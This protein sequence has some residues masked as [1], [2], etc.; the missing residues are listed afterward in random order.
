MRISLKQIA[1][2]LGVSAA[3]VSLVLNEKNGNGRISKE[4]SKKVL[5][6]AAELNYTPN[7]FAKGLKTGRSKTL[8]LIL[9]DISNPF[10][11]RL[12]L[13]VQDYAEKEGYTVLVA[14][15]NEKVDKTRKMV[16]LLKARQVDGFI[17]TP[18]AGSE[19][20][21]EE[22]MNERIP[23]V[24]VDR[25]FPLL[26]T[27][28]VLIN[29]FEVSYRATQAL[30]S[31]G[32]ENLAFLTF[33]Q[34]QHNMI[35][36]KRGFIEAVD[37]AGIYKPNLVKEVSY[38]FVE[39]DVANAMSD[40]ISDQTKIDGIFFANVDLSLKGIRNLLQQNI[41]VQE[42][43]KIMCFDESEAFSILPF[44]V[45]YIK[46]PINEMSKLAVRLV[47]DQIHNKIVNKKYILDATLFTN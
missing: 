24:L 10:F 35:E 34:N 28:S 26:N 3:T 7:T 19:K 43:I 47:I 46:Q 13:Y 22:L 32:C 21:I 27:N 39:S 38:E 29:N 2:E 42:Q 20:I 37:D 33:N 15:T 12:A 9:A 31:Q 25:S 40:F 4:M 1:K 18:A 14:N 36:R 16:K 8:G 30:I 44:S 45:P 23:L 17:I 6:K 5:E 41:K 11:A